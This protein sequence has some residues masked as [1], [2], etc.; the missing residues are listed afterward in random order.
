MSVS[1]LPLRL[2]PIKGESLPGFMIRLAERNGVSSPQTIAKALGSPYS[3]LQAAALGPFDLQSVADGAGV[4]IERLAR[5]TYWPKGHGNELRF[6]EATVDVEMISLKQRKACPSCLSEEPFHRAAWDL[7]LVTACPAH[8][9]RLISTC[10]ECGRRLRWQTA[11]ITKC[12][13]GA[14]LRREST[15]PVSPS[16]LDGLALIYGALG[17]CDFED[18]RTE[19]LAGLPFK[20]L[21]ALMVHLG[22]FGSG[23]RQ[24][25]AP[26]LLSRRDLSPH[27]YLQIGFT[28]CQDWPD[29]FYQYLEAL[30]QRSTAPYW[31]ATRVRLLAEWVAD[32]ARSE[33]LRSL[34]LPCLQAFMNQGC[35][36]RVEYHLQ[37]AFSATRPQSSRIR[38]D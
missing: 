3:T 6:L 2:A 9:V 34:V 11:S 18:K 8:K 32:P 15:E 24:R 17:L 26:V 36:P 28:A 30:C 12:L 14:D 16:E 25:F 19:S 33:A 22:W 20:D 29:S 10:Q 21:L 27:Q 13:C 38:E 7:R 4:P 23:A 1:R 5:M 31:R 37:R 35:D